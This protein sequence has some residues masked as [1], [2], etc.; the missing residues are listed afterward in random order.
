MTGW[1]GGKAGERRTLLKSQQRKR[2]NG[3]RPSG[4]SISEDGRNYIGNGLV[5]VP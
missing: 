5:P 2:G 3:L 1:G 4:G